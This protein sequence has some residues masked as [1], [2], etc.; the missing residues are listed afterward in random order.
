MYN[1]LLSHCAA[2]IDVFS[3]SLCSDDKDSGKV[4]ADDFFTG[5]GSPVAVHR[6]LAGKSE[7]TATL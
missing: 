5:Q 4:S 7:Y 3:I 6:L 1:I 2:A